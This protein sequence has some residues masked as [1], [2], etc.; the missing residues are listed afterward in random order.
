MRNSTCRIS[1]LGLFIAAVLSLG[2]LAPS[3]SRAGFEEAQ[4]AYDKGQYD[5][6]FNAFREMAELGQPIAQFNLAVMYAKGQGTR[7]NRVYAFAWAQLAAENGY[8]KAQP[9]A[10]SIRDQLTPLSLKI[11]QEIHDEYS[12]AALD[13][14]LL[15]RVLVTG[16]DEGHARCKVREIRMASYP[17]E[18]LRRGIQGSLMAQVTVLP[19]G[20]ARNVRIIYAVPKGQ[21]EE[22]ARWSLMRSWFYPGEDAGK[23]VACTYT[24]FY[25]FIIDNASNDEYSDLNRF[26]AKIRAEAENGNVSSEM[27]YGMLLE[28]MPQFQAKSNEAMPWFVRAAQAGAPFA[29]FKLG[30]NLLTG[31]SCHCDVN[32]AVTWLQKAAAADETNAQVTLAGYLLRGTPGSDDVKRAIVWLE[33]AAAHGSRDGKLYL[34]ALLAAAPFPDVRDPTRALQLLDR[35]FVRSGDD[36]AQYE[37]RAAAKAHLGNFTGAVRDQSTAISCASNLKWD[38]TPLKERQMR[39]QW[40]QSWDGMLLTF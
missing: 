23:P 18:P 19:D 6:A 26:A 8:A 34:A 24:T 14:R 11:A 37:I 10:D 12:H 27:L 35:V 33:R 7:E 36:P 30:L 28:G 15:P 39:Y 29:Q 9:L 22:T 20:R 5:A 1:R 38:L 13:E 31:R 17:D 16:D 2:L 21:F 32:K 4:S 25:R 3:A 40:R